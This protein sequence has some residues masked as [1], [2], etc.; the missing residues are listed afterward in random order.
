[1]GEILLI[2]KYLLSLLYT[3][4]ENLVFLIN[5]TNLTSA[6]SCKSLTLAAIFF[7]LISVIISLP[8]LVARCLLLRLV[9]CGALTALRG[10][11][12]PLIRRMP[13]AK[14]LAGSCQARPEWGGVCVQDG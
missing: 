1:M 2:K 9:A 10:G 12:A 11:T 3:R 8:R 6:A 5:L 14:A 4:G 13:H 7:I